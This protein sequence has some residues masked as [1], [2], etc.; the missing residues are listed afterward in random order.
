MTSVAF[1]SPIQG[2]RR[3][4]KPAEWQLALPLTLAYSEHFIPQAIQALP[5]YAITHNPILCYNLLHLSTFVL[6]GLGAYLFVR[7]LTGDSRAGFIAGPPSGPA[8]I[9]SSAARLHQ[10]ACRRS[11]RAAPGL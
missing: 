5:I 6:S 4:L 9:R 11:S 8:P 10:A 1:T 7:E 2:E 3:W